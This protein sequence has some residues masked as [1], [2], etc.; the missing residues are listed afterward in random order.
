M[1][2]P[3]IYKI[4]KPQTSLW[5]NYVGLDLKKD[6]LVYTREVISVSKSRSRDVILK[7]LSLVSDWVSVWGFVYIPAIYRLG[8]FIVSDKWKPRQYK[9]RST[10]QTV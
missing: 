7:G 8:Y 4:S 3:E 10:L 5:Q 1:R 2:P 6:Y 9:F